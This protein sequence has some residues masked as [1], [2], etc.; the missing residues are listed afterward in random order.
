MKKILLIISAAIILPSISLF[1]YNNSP[2]II[3]SS[4]AG[5]INVQ[6][7]ELIYRVNLFGILPLA[8]V[9]IKVDERQ[10]NNGQEVYHLSATANSLRWYRKMYNANA[11]LDSYVDIVTHDPILFRQKAVIANGKAINK[12]VYYDQENG[13]MTLNNI[14]R[15]IPP[16]TQDP[17][18]LL[19][20]TMRMDFDK[21]KELEMNINTN[22]KNYVV[23]GIKHSRDISIDKKVYK[24]VFLDTDIK[25]REKS[26]Y[27]QS[28]IN[29][30]FCRGKENIPILIK[31]FASGAFLNARLIDIR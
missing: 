22:Q 5:K 28:K 2:K 25:R 9:V 18:S 24:L 15:R 29:I 6:A 7:K 21:V 8:D 3:V 12:E 23:K 27:H 16:H 30:T 10:D 26:P 11:I 4:L 19:V 17:L 20:N 1:Y 31:I 14:R 13:I